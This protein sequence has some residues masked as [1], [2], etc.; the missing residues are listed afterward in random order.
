MFEWLG[1]LLGVLLLMWKVW[2]MGFDRFHFLKVT[3]EAE[4]YHSSLS[5]H[6]YP[7]WSV[8]WVDVG[9]GWL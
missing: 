9:G 8:T 7:G 6:V 2:L 3:K 5:S 1:Y 4:S